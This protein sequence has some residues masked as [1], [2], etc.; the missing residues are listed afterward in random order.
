M[1]ASKRILLNTGVQYLRSGVYMLLTFLSTRYILRVLG[2]SDYGLYS[3][4]GSIVIILGFITSSLASST[5]RFLSYTHGLD[6]KNELKLIFSNAMTIHGAIALLLLLVMTVFESFIIS[7]LRIPATRIEAGEFVFFTVTLMIVLSFVTSPVRALFIARENIVYVSVVEMTDAVLKFV[8]AIALFFI[9][10]DSL[11]V[12]ALLM[13]SISVFNF[14]AY[15]LYAFYRYEECHIPR[16]SEISRSYIKKLTGFA[17]WNV[18]AVG[19]TVVRTQGISVILNRFFGTIINAAYGIALQLSN[20]VNTIAISILN[21]MNPPLMKAE[22]RGDRQAMLGFATKESKYSFIVLSVILLPAICEMPQILS[23]WLHESDVPEHT[24][25]F[26]NSLLIAFLIDQTTIGLTSANQAVGRIRNY[27]LLISTTRLLILPA[28]WLCLKLGYPVQSVMVVYVSF[29]TLCGI[30]RIPFLKY[31]AGLS[32][33]TYCVEVFLR[34]LLPVVAV[35][36]VSWSVTQYVQ[37]PF[38]FILTE[39]LGLAVGI[40][41]MY[42]VALTTAERMWIR[43]TLLRKKQRP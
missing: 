34:P 28:A 35:L 15:F 24:V 1:E 27:T 11:K 38:R 16:P 37:L 18:Y 5:Q 23:F 26:C 43:E 8:G 33:R 14:L 2:S 4:V 3:V 32:V 39:C 17:V 25:M 30:I 13:F 19:S 31:T 42:T 12:Y 9:P 40:A 6:D 10:Y 7:H 22:G 36:L 29:E 41:L 20:A 21:A